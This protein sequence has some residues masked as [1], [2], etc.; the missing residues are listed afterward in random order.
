WNDSK[1]N[2]SYNGNVANSATLSLMVQ[3][4]PRDLSHM[5]YADNH[6]RHKVVFYGTAP[7]IWGIT[8]GLRFSGLAGT[9][10]SLAVSGNMNAD[11]VSSN[12]LAYIYDSYHLNKSEQLITGIEILLNTYK[13]ET[14]LLQHK[15]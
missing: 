14:V 3:D 15:R 12:D 4:D 11:F 9:R 6:F 10:Y 13:S 1:D 7:S 2:T 8:F 5:A